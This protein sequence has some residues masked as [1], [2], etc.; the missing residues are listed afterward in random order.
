[1][2]ISIII[3]A[4][5]AE[6]YIERCVNS[7][8][9]QT[10]KNIEIIIV[11]D[12]SIDATKYKIEKIKDDRIIV[13]NKEN[14]GVSCAR[15]I[16]IKRATGRYIMFAD[17]DDYIEKDAVE[18]VV[19]IINNTNVD[20]V[21]FNYNNLNKDGKVEKGQEDYKQYENKELK[22]N[23]ILEFMEEVLR[24]KINAFVWTL[25]IKKEIVDTI[26]FNQKLGMMEDL[27]FYIELLPKI[28]NM[29]IINGGLYNYY[30][31]EESVSNSNKYYYK[32]FIDTLEVCSKIIESLKNNNCYNT[33]RRD[34][35]VLSKMLGIE[36]IF[37]KVCAEKNVQNKVLEDMLQ[38]KKIDEIIKQ[39]PKLEGLAIQRKINIKLIK[40]KRKI[41]LI[42]FN[43]IRYKLSK[44]KNNY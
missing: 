5:N 32:N 27:L 35:I 1:M 7:I 21:K 12:G 13:I 37:Y 20:V 6:K 23:E 33:E 8:I 40:K 2:K 26:N 25:A 19:N 11:N 4:Y 10:Y 28:N 36:S 39:L 9:N 24:G 30:I 43:K 31:N 44:L 34:M 22:K 18:K 16:G 15:N 41:F 42:I 29:Y 38:N 17:S 3:P 14:E